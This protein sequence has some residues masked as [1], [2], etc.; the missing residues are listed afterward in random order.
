MSVAVLSADSTNFL[1]EPTSSGLGDAAKKIVENIKKGISGMWDDHSIT[2]GHSLYEAR[3]LLNEIYG[4][5]SIADWDGVGARPIT[6]DAYE[7]ARK[8]I[9]T[10][11]SSIPMPDII[12]EPSGSLAMEWRKTGEELFII[13][14]SGKSRIVYAG[15]FGTNNVHGSEYFAG[16]LPPSLI[17]HLRRLYS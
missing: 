10:L 6:I 13:S 16:V 8:I 5:C 1:T 12:P 4:E 11:S 17:Q 7:E 9:A 3:N 2:F 15:I 14:L